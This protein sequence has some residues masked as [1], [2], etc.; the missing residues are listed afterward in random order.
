MRK[1]FI[2]LLCLSLWSSTLVFAQE[3]ASIFPEKGLQTFLGLDDTSSPPIVK[4][5]RASDIQNITLDITGA[6]SKRYG[7]SYHA[8]LDTNHVDDDFEAVTG[9]FELYKSDGTRTVLATCGS[10]IFSVSTAGVKTDITGDATVTEG[11]NNQFI[12]ITA[13][14]TAI[15]TNDTDV[16]IECSDS[17][18]G[19]LDVSDLTDTLTAAKAVAWWKNYL[20]FGNTVENSVERSTRIRWSNV[21]TTETWSDNDYVDIATLGGQ[22]IE[23]FGILYDNLYIFLTDSIYKV[24]LVGGDELIVVTKVSEGIGCIA[25][26]SVQNIQIGNSEGLIFLS[27]DKTIN[28]L[29]GVKVQEIST[30]IDGEM[31]DLS[32]SRL[33]YAVSIDDQTNAHYYLATTTGTASNNNLLL[34]F[35][36]GIGEWSKHIQIDVNAFGIAND[37]NT[38]PQVY[39]GNHK[40]FMY[41]MQDSD[42]DSDIDGVTGTFNDI[43]SGTLVTQDKADTSTA[44]GLIVLYDTSANFA[45]VTGAI[46]RA[47]GGTGSG[48]EYIIVQPMSG[49]SPSGII[50]VESTVTATGNT[51][52]SIGDIDAFYTTKW[53]DLGIAPQRKQFG[54]IFLWSN[55]TTSGD[56]TVTYGT[57]FT[58]TLTTSTIE[59]QAD[60][61]LWGTGIWG[62]AEWAGISSSLSRIPLNV[63][64]R[65]IKVKFREAD[66]DESMSLYGYSIIYWPLD[67]F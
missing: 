23:A 29:D 60:G 12:W 58:D 33:P 14:D 3:K 31:D 35:H 63:S 55:T 62:V 21:G 47:T 41:Q 17:T 56:I 40:S 15:G 7:Y 10:N 11:Q 16:P 39:F 65:Y 27:R 6:A 43:V 48:T 4:D 9:I 28:Y 45:N 44:S 18:C 66:I 50:V 53:Y 64:G 2:T 30:Y 25:K 1:L 49:P 36:Y 24:S 42:L 20:I 8:L 52:Y 19:P 51:V 67:V 32:A 22:E 38:I 34:D 5:G 46:V 13:L 26:G 57:D 54:E 37:A 59:L 61:D